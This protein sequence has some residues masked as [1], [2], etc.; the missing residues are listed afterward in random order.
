MGNLAYSEAAD[1]DHEQEKTLNTAKHSENSKTA[2]PSNSL[3]SNTAQI[4]VDLDREETVGPKAKGSLFDTMWELKKQA[5]GFC[6]LHHLYLS[7]HVSLTFKQIQCVLE[8][9][10]TERDKKLKEEALIL[11]S[12]AE[13]TALKGVGEIAMGIHY[14]KPIQTG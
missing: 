13:K 4:S 5:E 10:E 11:N 2:D 14:D 1:S 3:S 12:V 9:R 8:K 6:S 7:F